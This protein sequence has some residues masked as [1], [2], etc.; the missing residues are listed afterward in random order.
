MKTLQLSEEKAKELYKTASPEFRAMLEE[1][2]GESFFQS[3]DTVEDAEKYLEVSPNFNM[4]VDDKYLDRL[5]A[6]Y[7]LSILCDA[8]NKQDNFVPD[9][10][11]NNQD[12]WYPA[13]S[14]AGYGFSNSINAASFVHATFGSQFCF[15]SKQRSDEFGEKSEGLFKIFLRG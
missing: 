11:D 5:E 15:K 7:N 4:R 2:F 1:T 6:F 14:H 3:I 10:D 12:K 8:W 13:F 9:F